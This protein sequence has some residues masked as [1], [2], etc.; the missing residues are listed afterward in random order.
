MSKQKR[1]DKYSAGE[2]IGLLLICLNLALQ[3]NPNDWRT[4]VWGIATQYGK[5]YGIK[6][7]D[8]DFIKSFMIRDAVEIIVEDKK[9][10]LSTKTKK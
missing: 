4:Y 1:F 6:R 7:D 10:K 3:E 8:F 2:Q 9:Q 5:R